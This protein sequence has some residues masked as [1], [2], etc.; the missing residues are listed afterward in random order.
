MVYKRQVATAALVAE[1]ESVRDEGDAAGR[2]D[3]RPL[4]AMRILRMIRVP[5]RES[6]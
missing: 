1:M 4:F 5:P 6:T 2:G 3:A